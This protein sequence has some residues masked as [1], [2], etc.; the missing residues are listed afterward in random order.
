MLPGWLLPLPSSM[1]VAPSLT[2]RSGPASAVG[3][4]GMVLS[5][6]ASGARKAGA[7]VI[8]VMMMIAPNPAYPLPLIGSL[9][10]GRRSTGHLQGT[11][12]VLPPDSPAIWAAGRHARLPPGAGEMVSK[13]GA[14]IL[15]VCAP[16]LPTTPLRR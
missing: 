7:A 5:A 8:M 4:A 2:V 14:L 12:R 15:R 13:A 1:T 10:G 3:R 9:H 11:G 6:A 16:H